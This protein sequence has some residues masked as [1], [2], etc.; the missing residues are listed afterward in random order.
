MEVVL[1]TSEQVCG[2]T[3]VAVLLARLDDAQPGAAVKDEDL[4]V[5]DRRS[6]VQ[7]SEVI[8]LVRAGMGTVE[9]GDGAGHAGTPGI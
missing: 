2:N 7:Q 4:A 5:P 3:P 9:G 6:V 1:D 8:T